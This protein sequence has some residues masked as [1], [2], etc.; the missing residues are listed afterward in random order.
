ML[1][2]VPE[3]AFM[4]RGSTNKRVNTKGSNN[5]ITT[6]FL[7]QNKAVRNPRLTNFRIRENP[8]ALNKKWQCTI[9]RYFPLKY[10]NNIQQERE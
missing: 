5:A 3:K 4:D 10:E 2:N 8:Y 9:V 1:N 6:Y 7:H